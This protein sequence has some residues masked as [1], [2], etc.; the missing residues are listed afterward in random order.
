MTC[1]DCKAIDASS[2]LSSNCLFLSILRFVWKFGSIS[3]LNTFS[4]ANYIALEKF[5]SLYSLKKK[6]SY[7]TFWMATPITTSFACS[8]LL[9][10]LT[11]DNMSY[12]MTIATINS[13]LPSSL[14]VKELD[15]LLVNVSSSL[16]ATCNKSLPYFL[17]LKPYSLHTINTTLPASSWQW[18]ESKSLLV[19]L[20]V[21]IWLKR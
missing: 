14:S 18:L 5:V 1:A 20:S 7:C 9:T 6:I 2:R 21:N 3:I 4:L 16:S 8:Y 15:S 12:Q 19:A 17:N 11:L 10:K 13:K